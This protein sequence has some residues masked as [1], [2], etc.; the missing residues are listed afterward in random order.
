MLQKFL[1]AIIVEEWAREHD[2]RD[3]EPPLIEASPLAKELSAKTLGWLEAGPP[4]AYHEMAILLS[5]LHGECHTLLQSFAIDFKLPAMSIP[6][7]GNTID[8]TGADSTAF[9][10]ETAKAA[11]GPIFTALKDLLGKRKAKD[12]APLTDKRDAIDASIKRYFE[13]KAEYDTRV[14]AAFAAA[15][16][17]LKSTPDKVT[18]LVKGIMNGIKVSLDKSNDCAAF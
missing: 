4:A 7:I 8:L 18:P 6:T 2:K 9:N 16:I 3:G 11:T 13:T 12:L 1:A 15:F 14:S 10:I 17:S 5:R